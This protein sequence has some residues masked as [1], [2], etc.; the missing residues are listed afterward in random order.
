MLYESYEWYRKTFSPME[1]MAEHCSS[2]L[3]H[4]LNPFSL[5]PANQAAASLWD[6]YVN[7][8][9]KY[10]YPNF[11]F[12]SITI[13]GKAATIENTA[14]DKTPFCHFRRFRTLQNNKPVLATP[15]QHRRSNR[16]KNGR[17]SAPNSDTLAIISP[18][19]GNYAVVFN[20]VIRCFLPHSMVWITDWVDAR[21]IPLAEGRFGLDENVAHIVHLLKTQSPAHVICFSQ[22][23]NPTLMALAL[24][25]KEQ[26]TAV[27]E[28]LTMI[29]GP[30]DARVN[31]GILS[32]IMDD[33]DWVV[34]NLIMTVPDGH[35][36]AGRKVFPGFLQHAGFMGLHWDKQIKT[37]WKHFFSA[38]SGRL[39]RSAQTNKKS[40]LLNT[41]MDIPA[42]HYLENMEHFFLLHSLVK[43]DLTCLG[44]KIDLSA[45]RDNTA[46]MVVEGARD[47]FCPPGQTQAVFDILTNLPKSAQKYLLVDDCG[48]FGLVGGHHFCETIYPTMLSW[49][50][51][52]GNTPKRAPKHSSH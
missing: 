49:M 27:P 31:N 48:H 6:R 26:E 51:K 50:Q 30:I 11:I 22:S 41:V 33:Y 10:E 7:T 19:S 1:T 18:I 8:T 40:G 13:D 12:P 38:A 37:D 4:P 35:K 24:L 2:F 15:L 32:H 20:E 17:V 45:I 46:I 47:I 36:G 16:K 21:E 29:G 25:E 28:T 52:D 39:D 5:T 9:A 34:Q 42:E 43:G 14:V 23:A 3:R 44:K